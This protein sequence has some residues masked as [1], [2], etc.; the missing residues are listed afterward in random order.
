MRHCGIW[1]APDL[2]MPIAPEAPELH[3]G[4]GAVVVELEHTCRANKKQSAP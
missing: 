3:A 4:L 2:N 1:T